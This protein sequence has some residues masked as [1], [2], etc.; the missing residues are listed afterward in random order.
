[1]NEYL[2]S[3][4]STEVRSLGELVEWNRQHADQEL[5]KGMDA[6]RLQIRLRYLIQGQNIRPSP[7]SRAR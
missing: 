3:L 4:T 1:M 5:P 7:L 6:L 2:E